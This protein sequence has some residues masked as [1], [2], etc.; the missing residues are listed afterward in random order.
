MNAAAWPPFVPTSRSVTA[1]LRRRRRSVRVER[2]DGARAREAYTGRPRRG[3][4]S[5]GPTMPAPGLG[6]TCRRRGRRSRASRRRRRR[7]AALRAACRAEARRDSRRLHP[8]RSAATPARLRAR[9]RRG[10]RRRTRSSS[11]AESWDDVEAV[12]CIDSFR[13]EDLAGVGSE[14]VRARAEDEHRRRHSPGRERPA[15]HRR[16][17]GSRTRPPRRRATFDRGRC[18]PCPAERARRRQRRGPRGRRE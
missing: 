16:R 3:T 14:R 7:R 13:L 8:R 15:T 10:R 6:S 4:A 5:S 2:R 12:E 1:G 9:P 17:A 11:D 18:T